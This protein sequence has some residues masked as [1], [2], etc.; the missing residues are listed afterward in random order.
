VSDEDEEPPE[1]MAPELRDGLEGVVVELEL[2][3]R[4]GLAELPVEELG[5]R[6]QPVS[7]APDRAT[8]KAAK[9]VRFI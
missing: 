2:E 3:L 9:S 1:L 7:S 8:A 4:S 5:P 6:S